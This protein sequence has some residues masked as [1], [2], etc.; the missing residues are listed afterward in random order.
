MST[1]VVTQGVGCSERDTMVLKAPPWF[2][3]KV[4]LR[5]PNHRAIFRGEQCPFNLWHPPATQ[6]Q[7]VLI[8]QTVSMT[9][10]GTESATFEFDT[11]TRYHSATRPKIV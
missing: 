10:A 4:S 1:E 3:P 8:L 6:Q 7:I 11:P 9:P 5:K 2:D